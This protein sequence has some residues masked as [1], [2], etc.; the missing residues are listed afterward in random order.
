MKEG[1]VIGWHYAEVDYGMY[2]KIRTIL[3][4]FPAEGCTSKG[5]MDQLPTIRLCGGCGVG[6]LA[7]LWAWLSSVKASDEFLTGVVEAEDLTN[8][9]KT[10]EE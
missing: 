10:N 9:T 1:E 3:P 6:E 4:I 2:G 5:G 7:S 8:N